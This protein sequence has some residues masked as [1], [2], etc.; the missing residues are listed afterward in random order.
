MRAAIFDFDG[1]LVDS[2][3]LH[4]RAMRDSLLP[5]GITIDEEEYTR[6]YLA[7]DDRGALRRAL[8]E[9]GVPFDLDRLDLVARRKASIFQAMLSDIPLFPGV[10]DLLSALA[11]EVPVAIASGALRTEIESI[12]TSAGIRALF[13]AVVG[14]DDV[15]QGKPH[16]E[17]YLTAMNRIVASAPD[18]KP[19]EC[20]VVEDSPPGIAAG[21]AAG[22]KVVAVSNSYPH[23]ALAAAH[24]I[25]ESLADVRPSDLRALFES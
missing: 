15:S 24:H 21:L 14:A 16:P 3:P 22:M 18:L 4:Y 25:V 7:Y 1:V 12:L 20:V 11:A 10:R 8:E 17:P 6:V 23:S 2:E 13:R 9:H 5:E 19:E